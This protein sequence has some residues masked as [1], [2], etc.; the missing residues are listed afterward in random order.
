MTSDTL[1]ANIFTFA[2]FIPAYDGTFPIHDFLTELE[3]TAHMAQWPDNITLKIAKS[4][5]QG[6]PEKVL[7]ENLELRSCTNLPDFKRLAIQAFTT[8]SRPM[9]LRLQD[10]MTCN[11][12]T[13]ETVS[14]YADRLRTFGKQLT[15]WDADEKTKIL[16]DQTLC[17]QFIKGLRAPMIR[18]LV[19]SQ[20]P[21]TFSRALDLARSEERNETLTHRP[22]PPAEIINNIPTSATVSDDPLSTLN[23]RIAALELTQAQQAVSQPRWRARQRPQCQICNRTNHSTPQ[24]FYNPCNNRRPNH[25][26]RSRSRPQRFRSPYPPRSRN[27]TPYRYSDRRPSS[28]RRR[29]SHQDRRYSR[30]PSYSPPDSRR[31]SRSPSTSPSRQRSSARSRRQD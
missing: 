13:N 27:P 22:E 21:T 7:R 12:T 26:H 1:P 11:Q 18:R 24:C 8:D 14:S 23:A 16:K 5:F 6:K 29:P 15:E 17:A 9:S 25:W 30:T 4:K 31:S 10:V 28:E 3:D 2:N 19:M 20:N